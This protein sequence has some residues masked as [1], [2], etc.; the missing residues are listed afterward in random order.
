MRG[1]SVIKACRHCGVKMTVWHSQRDRKHFCSKA[2]KVVGVR[3]RVTR[4]CRECRLPYDTY[5]ALNKYWCSRKCRDK[6]RDDERFES[7]IQKTDG[8][9]LWTSDIQPSGYGVFTP[10]ASRKGM[11]AHRFAYSK[12][13]GQIPAGLQIDHLCFNRR[14]VNPA[15][16]EAVTPLVNTRRARA[17]KRTQIEL[18]RRIG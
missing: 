8:C 15:H 17:R 3:I 18:E 12:W 16:L 5:P 6:N 2:C 14:C 10:H 1:P 4:I 9:W 13:V 7:R 11:P